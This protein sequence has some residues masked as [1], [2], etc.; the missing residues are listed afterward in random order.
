MSYLFL[1]FLSIPSIILLSRHSQR[2]EI[3]LQFLAIAALLFLGGKIFKFS[4]CTR[5]IGLLM[6]ALGVAGYYFLVIGPLVKGQII[7][8]GIF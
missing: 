6:I 1:A 7:S 5:I 4:G 8:L 2:T 3:V